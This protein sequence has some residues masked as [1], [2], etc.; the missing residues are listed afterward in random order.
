MKM[1]TKTQDDEF[2][3]GLRILICMVK[4][5]AKRTDQDLEHLE[6]APFPEGTSCQS[7]LDEAPDLERQLALITSH[8]G[9]RQTFQAAFALAYADGNCSDGEQGILEEIQIRW[10]IPESYPVLLGRMLQEAKDTVLPSSVRNLWDEGRQAADARGAMLGSSLLCGVLGSLPAW[11]FSMAS[12]LAMEAIQVRLVRDIGLRRRHEI[13]QR[14]ARALVRGMGLGSGIRMAANLCFKS[15]PAHRVAWCVSNAFASTWALCEVAARHV[16]AG[17]K[18]SSSDLAQNFHEA[19]D[20]GWEA[21]RA[22]RA[23]AGLAG[24]RCQ[25]TLVAL[26]HELAYGRLSAEDYA[27]KIAALAEPLAATQ[28]MAAGCPA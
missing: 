7:M 15:A 1:S 28:A 16:E 8:E 22:H 19:C 18:Y 2:R 26:G 6:S 10:A 27:G 9:H 3:A 12:D 14:A 13:S 21:F 4:A 11:E 20:R 25:G 24:K 17:A 23:A 5:N